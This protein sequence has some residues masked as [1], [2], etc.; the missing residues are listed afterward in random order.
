MM[1][2]L[3]NDA[4][5]YGR[6]ARFHHCFGDEDGMQWLKRHLVGI[7]SNNFCLSNLGGF[8]QYRFFKFHKLFS[9]VNQHHV[10][11]VLLQMLLR[12]KGQGFW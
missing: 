2:H 12:E 8:F 9:I 6:N 3:A 1:C 4:L 7:F 11:E 10:A 5:R